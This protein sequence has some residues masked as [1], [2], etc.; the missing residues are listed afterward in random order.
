MVSVTGDPAH[1][2]LG[3]PGVA[4]EYAVRMRAFGQQALWTKRLAEGMLS[5][6][7]ID[8]LAALLARFHQ[9]A[10]IAPADSPWGTSATIAAGADATMATLERLAS[11][12]AS[13]EALVRLRRWDS[14]QRRTL[15]PVF[16]RR[17]SDGMVRECHGDLHAGNIL[18]TGQ[19]VEVF[20]CIEFSEVLRWIDVMNDLAFA[21][22]DLAC[23]Q[24]RDLSARLRNAYLALTGDYDGLALLGYYSVHRA[25]VRNLVLLLQGSQAANP[26]EKAACEKQ[27][28]AYLAWAD[29]AAKPGTPAILITHGFSGSGK[30]S[31]SRQAAEVLGAV[32]LRSDLERKRL[33]GLVPEDR[34]GSLPGAALYD[35]TATERAYARLEQLAHTVTAAGHIALIDAAFLVAAQRERFARCAARLGVPF[36]IFDMQASPATMTVRLAARAEAGTDASDAG[37]QVLAQQLATAEPLSAAEKEKTAVVDMEA[38]LTHAAVVSA[39]RQLAGSTG[40]FCVE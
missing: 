10:A 23:H 4:I 35:A 20:D 27:G 9:S 25:L 36:F 12:A 38:G 21:C 31:F 2:R 30:T 40:I 6:A 37:V 33:H 15:A 7:D 26:G 32:H 34:S 11:D 13:R 3:E 17:K 29:D 22:M 8:A 24:R 28:R 16:S 5:G 39:C 18:T 19:G 14:E 1:P